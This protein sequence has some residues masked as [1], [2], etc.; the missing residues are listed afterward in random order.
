VLEEA[1]AGGT[2]DWTSGWTAIGAFEE[3]GDSA[4]WGVVT[5]VCEIA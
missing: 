5:G 3:F 4:A 2:L 1:S